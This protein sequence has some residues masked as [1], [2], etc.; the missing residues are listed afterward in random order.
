MDLAILGS[1]GFVHKI[2]SDQVCSFPYVR[3]FLFLIFL[4]TGA[5]FLERSASAQSPEDRIYAIEVEGNR[6]IELQAILGKLSIKAGDPLSQEAI[7]EQI[8]R[9]YG[10]GFFKEVDVSTEAK[11]NGV[12]VVFRVKEKPFTVEVV[13][14]GND[15]LSDDKLNE[16]NTVKNQ[17]FLDMEQVKVSVENFRKLYQEKGFYHARIVPII[18]MVE[19]NQARLTFYI[20][21]GRQAHIRTIEFEGRNVLKKKELLAFMANREYSWPWSIFSDAGI[22]HRD[23]LPND[24]ERIKEVYLNKGYL[25]VQVGMPR[26]D[27]DETKE[28]FTLVFSIV[29]GEPYIVSQIQYA[30]NTLFS[31]AELREGLTIEAGEVFQRAKIRDEITRVTD[32]YGSRGYAFAEVNPSVEPDPPTRSTRIGFAIQEGEMVRIRDIR[33]TGNDKTRDNVIRRELRVVERDMIDSPAIKR[34]FE[35]L[36][37]LNFFE[38]VE[39]LPKQIAPGEVDLDVKVKEKPTGSFSIGGGFSTLDQFTLIADITE[40]NLFG[41]GYLARIRGQVGGRRTLGTI[42]FRNPAIFDTLTSAQADLF[43]SR[44]NYLTYLEKKQGANLTFGRGFSE[45]LTGTFTLVAEKIKITNVDSDANDLIKDQKG[46]QSTTGFRAS[47]FR[48]SRDYYLDPRRGTRVGVRT[49]FG[50]DALGGSNNFYSVSFD[51]MKYTPLPFWDFRHA[52]RGRFGYGDGFHG[53]RFPIPEFFYVGGINTVRGFKFGRAGPVTDGNDP[54]GGNKQIVLNN[55]L[56][57]PV[58]P[59]AKLNGVLFFDYGKGFSQ[60]QSLSL[61]LRMAAG[62]EVRWISPF[63]PLRASFGRPLDG[64]S[65]DQKWVFEFSVGSVF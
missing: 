31:E 5:L 27:L 53:S 62:M 2:G 15:E 51:A 44:T 40:G 34:S 20:E 28:W 48:D 63:G 38:T 7:R 57:F 25:D 50:T 12:L 43:S 47:L 3:I 52:I 60:G 16:K 49:S 59:D 21:E 55:D 17:V 23:E 11:A 46:T 10:M 1:L 9:M 45:Y 37:N 29:E 30:G 35:R 6:H 32:L 56:I 41:R 22:L 61:D 64:P 18:D 39:I 54:E 13:F 36:N 4:V 19:N 58:L 24:V 65:K 26:V 8:Q 33:I 42:T 14:D